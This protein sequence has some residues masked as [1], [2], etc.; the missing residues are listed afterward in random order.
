[1]GQ[2]DI[3]GFEDYQITDDGRV[4]SKK[5]NKWLKPSQTQ[6]GYLYVCLS[7][8]GINYARRIHRLVAEAF[9]KNHDNKSSIDHINTIKTDNR[10]SNLRWVTPKENN[11][12]PLTKKKKSETAHKKNVYQF[13]LNGE[14]VNIWKS[15][16]ECGRNGYNRGNVCLC[17]NNKYLM[18][19]NN[20]YKGFKWSYE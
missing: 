12:N 17:C 10:V 3:K 2:V 9:I 16:A 19:G 4:W 5:K 18:K 1:M 7:K 15:F 11:N 13:T 6:K 8:D 20:V 14:L